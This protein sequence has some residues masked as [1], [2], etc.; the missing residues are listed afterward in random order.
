MP[1]GIALKNNDQTEQIAYSNT[2]VIAEP[3]IKLEQA[4]RRAIKK[5]E[6][7]Q[8]YGIPQAVNNVHGVGTRENAV[9]NSFAGNK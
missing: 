2:N 4:N 5:A 9:V 6:Q 8:K 7:L 3:A 1:N